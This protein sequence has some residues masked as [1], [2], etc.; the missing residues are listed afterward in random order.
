MNG[1]KMDAA[2][3]AAVAKNFHPSRG[4]KSGMQAVA[5]H[6][7]GHALSDKAASK[8]GLGS[9]E[10][11]SRQIVERARAKTGHKTNMSFAGKISG[12]AQYNFAETVAEAVSDWFCNGSKASKESRAVMSVVN[13]IL[14]R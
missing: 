3:D 13:S 1:A 8:M 11:A 12:Y 14:R 10:E 7:Y 5:S 4:N 6:E 2:Y 9:L